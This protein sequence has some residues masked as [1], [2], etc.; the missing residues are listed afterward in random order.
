M[1]PIDWLAGR[2]GNRM[3]QLAYIIAQEKRGLIP[4]I[5]LQYPALF[6]EYETDIQRI[7]GQGIVESRPQVSVHVR[8]GDYVGHHMFVN[9]GE[10]D[11]YERAMALFPGREFLV[12]S[13]DLKWCKTRWHNA[14]GVTFAQGRDEI[15]DLN[16]MAECQDNIIA[17]S[18][19]SWWGAYLNPN[20]SKRVIAP[21]AWHTDGVQRIGFPPGWEVI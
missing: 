6:H 12:F 14:P 2:L 10:T 18:S 17:N 21:K 3:F 11:Y 20:L 7:F 15:A 8:R 19:F 16:M 5:W 4:D 9:L 1:V 13:D